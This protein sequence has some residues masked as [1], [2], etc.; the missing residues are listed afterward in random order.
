MIKPKRKRPNDAMQLA[1]SVFQDVISVADPKPAKNPAAVALGRLGG[2]KGGHA[3]AQKLTKEQRIQ[4]AKTAAQARW[5]GKS[6]RP[7]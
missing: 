2:L 1:H 4:S 3:R 5:K 6:H 7:G